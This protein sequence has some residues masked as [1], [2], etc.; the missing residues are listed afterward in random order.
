[1]RSTAVLGILALLTGCGGGPAPLPAGRISA[2]FPL[3]GVADT[4]YVDAID[5]LAMRGAELVAPDG[6]TTGAIS[7]V[8]LPA[9]VESTALALPTGAGGAAAPAALAGISPSTGVVGAAVQTQSQLLAI[10]SRARVALP[11]PVAYRRA[12]QKYRIRLRFGDPPNAESREITAP[13]PPPA[14]GSPSLQPASG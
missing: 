1:M 5:R 9:P 3:G 13:E 7:I 10:V 11:D 2:Y 14:A 4:I 8:A 12:W 6:R